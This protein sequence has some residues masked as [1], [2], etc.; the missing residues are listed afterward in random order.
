[1][2]FALGFHIRL[3]EDWG[4]R[5]RHVDASVGSGSIQAHIDDV[6]SCFKTIR[7]LKENNHFG[8]ASLNEL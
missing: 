3:E 1:V 2:E 8:S 5:V 4:T 6:I 7:I